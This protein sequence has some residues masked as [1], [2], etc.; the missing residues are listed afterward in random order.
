MREAPA[1]LAQMDERDRIPHEIIVA[2]NAP[3]S[4]RPKWSR[5]CRGVRRRMNPDG[6]AMCATATWKVSGIEQDHS[7]A[8][9]DILGLSTTTLTVEKVR[10]RVTAAFF[11]QYSYDVKQGSILVPSQFSGDANLHNLLNRYRRFVIIKTR[12]GGQGD[13]SLNGANMALRPRVPQR[14]VPF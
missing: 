7:A 3:M 9:A 13:R 10:L 12:C 1:R 2:N 5:A 8:Q 14:A 4:L 11:S 6:G